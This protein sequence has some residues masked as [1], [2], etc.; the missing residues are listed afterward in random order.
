MK[1]LV[2]SKYGPKGASSRYRFYNYEFYL[3]KHGIELEFSPLLSDNYIDN[4]YNKKKV[5]KFLWQFL[6]VI[7]RIFFLLFL[8]NEKYDV[9]IIEKELFPNIP[10]FIEAI[11]LKKNRYLLDFDDYI[12]A[13]YKTHPIFKILLYNKIDKLVER[14]DLTTVGNNWYFSEFKKGNLVYL[15]TVINLNDYPLQ[16]R[17]NTNKIIVWIGSPTTVKYLRLIESVLLKLINEISFT[18]K[19]IGGEV[20]LDKS[21]PVKT[22]KWNEY[23]ENAELASCDIGIM[24]LKDT[25]WEKGKC[26]FKLI[27]YMASGL[28]VVGSDLPANEEIIL[29][30][31]TGFIAKNDT[32]WYNYLKYL[33]INTE[34]AHRMGKNGRKRVED[35]YSYQAWGDKYALI[36]QETIK[37]SE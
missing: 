22:I 6:S 20:E 15:P 27:Q 31:E 30:E 23:S 14:A 12:A 28:P 7:K 29:H 18:V 34:E 17:H 32:D 26:G 5:K 10:Y 33:L 9:F 8:K 21:I 3:K 35:Y 4:L 37:Q 2:L 16:K 1:I 13:S 11:L 19:V 36:I 24:P 25:L